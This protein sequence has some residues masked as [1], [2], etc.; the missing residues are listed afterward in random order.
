MLPSELR[1][2][3]RENRPD[4][5]E[6]VPGTA[7]LYDAICQLATLVGFPPPAESGEATAY[8]DELHAHIA[9]QRPK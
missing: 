9:G 1:S 4:L 7:R 5:Y 3:L 6:A 2:W 8:L